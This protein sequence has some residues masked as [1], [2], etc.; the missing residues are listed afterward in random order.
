MFKL[1]YKHLNIPIC[2]L[3]HFQYSKKQ[4]QKKKQ[5]K[6]TLYVKVIIVKADRQE[7]TQNN[8][9]QLQQEQQ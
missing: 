9:W 8:N 5:K 3:L 1:K 7:A 2:R 4:K 6:K